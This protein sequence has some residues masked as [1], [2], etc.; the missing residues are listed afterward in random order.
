MTHSESIILPNPDLL[1]KL[2]ADNFT[3]SP[4]EGYEHTEAFN[5]DDIQVSTIHRIHYAQYGKPDGKPV[6]FFHGGPGGTGAVATN[7]RF[8]DPAVFRVVLLDQRGA[9][10]ST[11]HADTREN[12]TQLLIQ[13]TET[14]RE[15]LGIKKWHM[16]F[17]GSWGSTLAL[18]YAQAHPE[19]CGSLVLRGVFLGVTD[20]SF[21]MKSTGLLYPQEADRMLGYL[22]E[23]ARSTPLE[24]YHKLIMS[25]DQKVA[26]EAA[27]EWNR[28]ELSTSKIKQDSVEDIEAKLADEVWN[29][30]HAKMETHYFMN[31]CFL[32]KDQLL[33]GCE[34]IKHIPTRIVTGRFDVVCPPREAYEVHKRLPWS[35]LTLSP[36]SGHSAFEPEN[37]KTLVEYCDELGQKDLHL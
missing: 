2:F 37:L 19:V 35:T 28:W 16:V 10:K 3:M 4:A 25:E 21:I 18:A 27:A 9:G 34:K 36:L 12:T 23:E 26:N 15:R 5:Q 11:P 17:G 13:D 8:F 33:N 14:L 20:F 6:I 30:Q 29:M 1:N 7:A 31:G 22:P 24:S 32:E